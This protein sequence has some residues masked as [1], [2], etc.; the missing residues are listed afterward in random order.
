VPKFEKIKKYFY[1]SLR[2]TI[3]HKKPFCVGLLLLS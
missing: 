2:W 1:Q 3:L